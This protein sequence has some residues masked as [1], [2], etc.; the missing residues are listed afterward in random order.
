MKYYCYL[1]PDNVTICC[2]LTADTIPEEV[3]DVVEIEVED[4]EQIIVDGGRIIALD[5]KEYENKKR[6][7]KIRES[8]EM[9]K[10]R[11]VQ[12]CKENDNEYMRYH[13]RV[14]LNM[15]T[16][17]DGAR[18]DNNMLKYKIVTERY[19]NLKNAIKEMSLSDLNDIERQIA[20]IFEV[21][22]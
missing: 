2:S 19:E 17:E 21:N 6:D 13:K 8:L 5:Y 15:S 10:S 16:I 18:F 4:V 12:W 7:K 1:L 9:L 11:Y 20:S 3:Q 14:I 22:E